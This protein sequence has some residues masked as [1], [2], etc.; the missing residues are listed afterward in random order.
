MAQYK[1]QPAP[2]ERSPYDARKRAR[3]YEIRC[4]T[5]AAS[6]I[7]SSQMGAGRKFDENG[8][9]EKLANVDYYLFVDVT[10][11]TIRAGSLPVY[12]VTSARVRTL[13]AAGKLG[14]GGRI[15]RSTFLK[16]IS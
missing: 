11:A 14:K 1:M 8:F 10:P 13:Y 2:T 6:F 16:L 12:Q 7:P 5:D 9:M 3:R 15:A 4:L